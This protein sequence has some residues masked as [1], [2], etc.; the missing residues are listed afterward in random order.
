MNRAQST[1]NQPQ[2]FFVTFF[3]FHDLYIWAGGVVLTTR[4]WMYGTQ[5]LKRSLKSTNGD[6]N[7]VLNFNNLDIVEDQVTMRQAKHD[8]G[9]PNYYVDDQL[10]S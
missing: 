4:K 8:A 3:E 2:D 5:F 10:K 7:T 1:F 9:I 6:D